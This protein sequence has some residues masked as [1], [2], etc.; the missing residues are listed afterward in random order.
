[1]AQTV[2]PICQSCGM[3]IQD[4][5]DFGTTTS[6]AKNL[7]YCRFCF[8]NGKFTDPDITLEQMIEKCTGIAAT[9]KNMTE[10]KA[11]EIVSDYMP[12]L[13]RWYVKSKG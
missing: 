4:P 1:M 7:N 13:K 12:K 10:D 6:A 3:A 9:K 5:N 2:G 11:K 8:L